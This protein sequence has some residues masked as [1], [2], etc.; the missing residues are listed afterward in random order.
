[1]ER[2]ITREDLPSCDEV[3]RLFDRNRI[4]WLVLPFMAGLH[5]LERSGRLAA[6]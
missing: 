5:S 2:T 4:N 6:G 1:M 3:V